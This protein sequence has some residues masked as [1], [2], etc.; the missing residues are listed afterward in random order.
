MSAKVELKCLDAAMRSA[1]SSLSSPPTR[2]AR[3]PLEEQVH[4]RKMTAAIDEHTGVE[5]ASPR[6]DIETASGDQ[7][8]KSR[9]QGLSLIQGQGL[10]SIVQVQ[11]EVEAHFGRD[12]MALNETASS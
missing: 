3:W 1:T 12:R 11:D 6:P 10:Y 9:L 8:L 5:Q 2:Q 4:G 7:G